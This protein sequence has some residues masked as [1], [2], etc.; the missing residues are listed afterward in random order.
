MANQDGHFVKDTCRLYAVR[1]LAE[2]AAATLGN[3]QDFRRGRSADKAG[4]HAVND[5]GIG[6]DLSMKNFGA[7]PGHSS[8]STCHL[9]NKRPII[10]ACKA[11]NIIFL[12]DLA[13]LQF[14]LGL[15]FS[16]RAHLLF[17]GLC[18]CPCATVCLPLHAPFRFPRRLFLFRYFRW[19][20][21][22]SAPCHLYRPKCF[23]NRLA[24]LFEDSVND[25]MA[26]RTERYKIA[27]FLTSKTF[28]SDVM[29]LDFL[30]ATDCAWLAPES[31]LDSTPVRTF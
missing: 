5:A 30:R 6:G 21:Y 20:N 22:Q 29:Q 4:L 8:S 31:L 17:F 28:V 27:A 11:H 24:S 15:G 3:A 7:H 1:W 25:L 14:S 2:F 19:P 9:P 26:S 18:D 12:G 16:D 23:A 13:L 10:D